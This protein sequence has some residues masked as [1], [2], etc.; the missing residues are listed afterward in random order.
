M[1]KVVA[2]NENEIEKYRQKLFKAKEL[3]RKEQA[4]L[5]FE[6]KIEIV[7]NLN[8]FAKEWKQD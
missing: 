8:K 4:K 3:Y 1:Q 5:P 6:K 7:M 2:K